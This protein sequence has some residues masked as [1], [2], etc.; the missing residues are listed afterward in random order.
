MQKGKL[1][2]RI[3]IV[4]IAFAFFLCACQPTPDAPIVNAGDDTELNDKIEATPIPTPEAPEE[5]LSTIYNFPTEQTDEFE[6]TDTD[7]TVK[8]DADVVVPDVQSVPVVEV[9]PTIISGEFIKSFTEK[10]HPGVIFY[11]DEA[12]LLKSDA[13]KYLKNYQEK[14]AMSW[15]EFLENYQNGD[16]D[17]ARAYYEQCKAMVVEY[18]K[19]IPTLP[20]TH[21][22]SPTDFTYHTLDYYYA[23][24][25]MPETRYRAELYG[26]S[27]EDI[28]QSERQF[29][30]MTAQTDDSMYIQIHVESRAEGDIV[31]KFSYKI[32]PYLSQGHGPT[33]T[34]EQAGT[35]SL[36]ASEAIVM[37]S[38]TLEKM[39]LADEMA[40]SDVYVHNGTWFVKELKKGQSCYGYKLEYHR[41]FSGLVGSDVNIEND[42]AFVNGNEVLTITIQ[43]RMVTEITYESPYVITEVENEN[44]GLVSFEEAYEA[45]KKQAR[46]EYTLVNTCGY[47]N[48]DENDVMHVD[49]SVESCDLIIDEIRFVMVRIPIKNGGYR[50][51]P[52]WQFVGKTCVN[53]KDGTTNER[54]GRTFM[55]INAVDGTRI[56][57][58]EWK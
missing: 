34:A 47:V 30:K 29:V 25:S 18:E 50:Y 22:Q 56:S 11:D 23:N 12:V 40:L 27:W 15:E 37:G 20:E 58:I 54:D 42:Y 3:M 52:A 14:V 32:S 7:V 8:V 45:F 31:S 24:Y 38:E 17:D 48:I 44:V 43:H 16:E 51:V 39:G 6:S 49:E 4:F 53:F 35:T 19:L 55:T 26:D 21:E 46:L 41:G 36:S 33:W 28:I 10:M 13:Q 2:T 1:P 9:E 5:N 57:G